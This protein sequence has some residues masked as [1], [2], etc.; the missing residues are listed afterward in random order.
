MSSK[1]LSVSQLAKLSK[2]SVRT[3]HHYEEIGLFPAGGRTA[4]G[5]RRYGQ[6]DLERLQQILFFRELGFPL[7][8]IR[9]IVTDPEFDVAAALVLQRQLLMEKITHLHQVVGAVD[10]ALSTKRGDVMSHPATPE[11]MFEVFGK[12]PVER[13]A[14][15]AEVKERWG[16]TEAYQE[17]ARR[18]AKYSKAQWQTIKEEADQINA[19]LAAALGRGVPATAP[20][21]TAIAERHRQHTERWFYPC[22]PAMHGVVAQMYVEDP[23]FQ[24]TYEAIRPGLAA[25][26]RDAWQANAANAA[27]SS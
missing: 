20:E 24:A 27:S 13:E 16:P 14:E 23:R 6:E 4:S 12:D 25:Y 8:E 15:V 5:Y 19:D 18:T 9:R 17:S 11:E 1:S 7:E 10:R 26:A 22:T 21:A 2:V 3:L